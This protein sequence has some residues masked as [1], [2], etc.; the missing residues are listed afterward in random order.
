MSRTALILTVLL[1][2]L[3]SPRLADARSCRYNCIQKTPTLL[4]NKLTSDSEGRYRQYK[5][6]GSRDFLIAL[7]LNAMIHRSP[8][9]LFAPHDPFT[10]TRSSGASCV[11][12]VLIFIMW[13][14][15][16]MYGGA[17]LRESASVYRVDMGIYDAED[18][19]LLTG[20]P[21]VGLILFALNPLPQALELVGMTGI[22]LA[23]LWAAT[24]LRSPSYERCYQHLGR[25]I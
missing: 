13:I 11:I 12:D 15:V 10:P 4:A 19:A 20:T 3:A 17:G 9:Y 2:A 23:Q 21:V 8:S 6:N 1:Q 7:A 25:S 24:F 5:L 16:G 18:N 14:A 22:P